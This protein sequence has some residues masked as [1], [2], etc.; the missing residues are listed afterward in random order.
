[1]AE[2]TEILRQQGDYKKAAE[3]LSEGR[4]EEGFEELGASSA[5]PSYADDANRY[6]QLA[7]AYLAAA[8]EKS[9]GR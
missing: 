8:A 4:T 3:A 2:V 6:Q 1:M 9:A 5:G 7:D